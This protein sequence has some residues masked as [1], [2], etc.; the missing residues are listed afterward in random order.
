MRRLLL[1]FL[2]CSE[3]FSSQLLAQKD[4]PKVVVGIVVDQMCYDYLYRFY[5]QFGKDGFKRLMDKGAHF[6]NVT[7]NYV[8]TFT[9]PGHASIY[10]GST[11]SNHGIVANEWY[12]RPFGREVSCVED[13]TVSSVGST[14]KYGKCSP[15]FLRSNTITD[16]LKLTYPT[17]KVIGVS[18]KDRSAI[19]PAGHLSD[20]SYWYD[21]ATGNFITSTFY[22]PELPA[23]V[24]QF[25]SLNL[26]PKY[27]N[28]PWNLLKDSTCYTYIR[29]DNS[30]YEGLVGGKTSPVFPYDFSKAAPADQLSLFTIM[31]AA[32]TFLTDFAIQVLTG[33][34][35]GKHA[36]TD[37]LTISYSTPDI[38]GHTFGPYSLEMEDMYFRL[39][40]ELERLFLALD[41]QIGKGQY[42]VFL[43]ADHAVVPVPQ[44]LTDH[45]LPGGYLFLKDKTD[46]LKA[47]CIA[48]FGK[49]CLNTI[50]NDN[51]YL[52][53]EVLGTELEPKVIA[54]LKEE[55]SKWKEVRK[56]YTKEEL[57]IKT[58]ENWQQMVTSGYDR[59]RSGEIIF[60]LQPGYLPKT[61]DTPGSRK[62]TSHG[63]AFN[64]DT[65]VP[66]LFYGKGI[67]PRE[68]FTPYE[69][70]D[71]TATLVHILNVQRPNTAIGK[72]MV[73]L[74]L[75]K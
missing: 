26:V 16:Q 71:I 46:N 53:D 39:D 13:T 33:E 63:S 56:V 73:E 40:R 49:N 20:G 69:I 14:S 4:A 31:P 57:Q 18:I 50:E 8:P 72:P 15:Y 75:K 3:L 60:I 10:T 32:N 24:N 70:V 38:A 35:L 30:P 41:K 9:G 51:V 62:G 61:S 36:T 47:L 48:K 5:P 22:R 43:T 2:L 17:S 11:P 54:L 1:L 44:F 52:A 67:L 12:Y 25:N 59:E 29:Q 37:F 27:V 34:Q 74:F 68:V 21:Y 7:Y 6:R 58:A 19:L 45:K 64:Y 55:I 65:H 66:V 23:W 42:V 28:Q